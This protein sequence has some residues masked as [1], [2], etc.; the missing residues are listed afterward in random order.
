LEKLKMANLNLW[1]KAYALSGTV[2]AV[3]TVGDTEVFNGP[4]TTTA[5]STPSHAVA[6]AI[7]SVTIDDAVMGT[8]TSVGISTSG[9][10]IILMGFGDADNPDG[11]SPG[12]L[13]SNV[14]VDGGSSYSPTDE[15]ILAEGIVVEEGSTPGEFHITI[16]DGWQVTFDNEFP[17]LPSPEPTSE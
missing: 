9:G 13:K 8:K 5:T 10:D 15:S 3:I 12:Q 1:G 7:A 4:V 14:S 11:A 6:E 17:E 16:A 2:T